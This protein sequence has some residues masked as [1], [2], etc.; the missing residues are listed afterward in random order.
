MLKLVSLPMLTG[1][2]G[3]VERLSSFTFM[4]ARKHQPDAKTEIKIQSSK[5]SVY[6]CVFIE[7]RISI[8]A[9]VVQSTW[10]RYRMFNR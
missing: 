7:L 5:A 9:Y 10:E 6:G 2:P 8:A 1:W 3:K 4:A